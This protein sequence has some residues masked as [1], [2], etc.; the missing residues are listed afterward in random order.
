MIEILFK[1]KR[2]DNCEW[3]EGCYTRYSEVLG[4]ITVDLINKEIYDIDPKT[5]SQFTNLTDKNGVKIFENDCFDVICESIINRKDKYTTVIGVVKRAKSGMWIVGFV[6][7]ETK[8]DAGIPL[9]YFLEKEKVIIGN[10]H[11][12]EE[13]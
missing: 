7:P 9:I 11:D 12:Q 4:M 2:L 5:V 3:V 10:I 1:A 13:K 6:N 8:E